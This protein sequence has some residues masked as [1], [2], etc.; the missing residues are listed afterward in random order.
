MG[1]TDEVRFQHTNRPGFWIGF[2]DFF[3]AGL[4]LLFYM[5]LGGLQEELARLSKIPRIRFR[6]GVYPEVDKSAPIESWF[7]HAKLACDRIRGDYTRQISIY[8]SEY[9][10]RELYHE[11]LINDMDKS[12][13]N[14]D[15]VV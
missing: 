15:F 12:I 14:R 13:E 10:E 7:D 2:I 1:S 6:I 4:F 11:R 9:N 8:N 3:T 5:P